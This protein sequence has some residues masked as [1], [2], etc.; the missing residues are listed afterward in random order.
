LKLEFF[1]QQA[2][3]KVPTN[4]QHFADLGVYKQLKKKTHLT[5][6]GLFPHLPGHAEADSRKV[7]IIVISFILIAIT[8]IAIII[9]AIHVIA[10]IIIAIIVIVI[11]VIAISVIAII[12]IEI[13]IIATIIFVIAGLQNT[14]E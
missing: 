5:K 1:L 3:T 2:L 12:V 6:D 8:F 13:I 14:N 11:I 4:V 9:I 7:N 10:I